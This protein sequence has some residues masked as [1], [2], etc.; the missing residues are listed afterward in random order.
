MSEFAGR[1]ACWLAAS[2]IPGGQREADS[3]TPTLSA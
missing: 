2:S 1:V 3:H